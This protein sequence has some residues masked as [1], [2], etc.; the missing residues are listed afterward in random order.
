VA[1]AEEKDPPPYGESIIAQIAFYLRLLHGSGDFALS[2]HEADGLASAIAGVA[3]YHVKLSGSGRGMAY[4][5]L[6][7]T[8]AMIY[9][10]KVMV[11]NAKAKAR[12]ERAPPPPS[13]PPD[14]NQ[15]VVN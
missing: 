7:G 15:M 12:K 5:A 2:E 1:L 11:A 4:L 8:A 3:R 9:T 14:P 10:P 13:D 6:A